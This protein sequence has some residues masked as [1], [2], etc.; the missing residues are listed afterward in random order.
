M[1][2]NEKDPRRDISYNSHVL[3]VAF[4]FLQPAWY[5]AC[6]EKANHHVPFVRIYI[7]YIVLVYVALRIASTI[8]L[9]SR[10]MN[11]SVQEENW[12]LLPWLI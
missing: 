3:L 4:H 12:R 8:N 2:L 9:N 1:K 11:I 5:M 10:C 7:L 6:I